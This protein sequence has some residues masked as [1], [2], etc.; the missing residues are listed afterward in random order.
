MFK[1]TMFF[2]LYSVPTA[3]EESKAMENIE[4]KKLIRA[5]LENPQ[6]VAPKQKEDKLRIKSNK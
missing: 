1:S 4:E 5:S 6:T 2:F 3:L